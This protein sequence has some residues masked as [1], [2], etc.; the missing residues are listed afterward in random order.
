MKDSY[1]QGYLYLVK[2]T[3]LP[4]VWELQYRENGKK[5]RRQIGT[6]EKLPT[7]AAAEKAAFALRSEINEQAELVLFDHLAAKYEAEEMPP[8]ESTQPAYRTN[9]KRLRERW[10]R[11][12]IDEM[13]KNTMQIEMWVRDLAK[14]RTGQPLQ[15][16]TKRNIVALLHV[17]F[18][19]AMQWGYVPLQRNPIDL[20]R[21]KGQE[22]KKKPRAVLDADLI[23]RLM[24]DDELPPMVKVI[25]TVAILTGL[26]A[27]EILGLKWE[28]INFETGMFT[29]E[30]SVVGKHSDATKTDASQAEVSMHPYLA[31]ALAKWKEFWPSVNG[32]VF[33]NPVTK[34]P[35]WRDSIQKDYLKPAGKKL[36]VS[37]LGWHTFRHTYRHM[38][39]GLLPVDV[40][41]QLMRHADIKTTM[42][43]GKASA[44]DVLRPANAMLVEKLLKKPEVVGTLV[45]QLP[46][47][48]S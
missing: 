1:Q 25:A 11:T 3:K 7:R 28:D 19:R 34:R 36:G 14:M 35:F 12:R 43:Y 2:R 37:D 13:C 47:S 18:E 8:R 29:V 23:L 27:S 4:D 40:Q 33:G 9:L 5:K 20:V 38:M 22:A 26:R 44:L 21:V 32:W 31:E 42:G 15:K 48:E 46:T 17:M 30:R 6:I 10:G 16:K 39:K 45:P 24:T 41:Q